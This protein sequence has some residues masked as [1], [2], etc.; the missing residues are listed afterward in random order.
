MTIAGRWTHRAAPRTLDSPRRPRTRERGPV[1]ICFPWPEREQRRRRVIS[2]Q[3]A[4]ALVFT[5]GTAVAGEAEPG[6]AD[7]HEQGDDRQQQRRD[8]DDDRDKRDQEAD[9]TAP[10]ALAL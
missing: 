2:A 4:E 1:H 9:R 5:L 10:P 7:D 8:R 3:D 6:E